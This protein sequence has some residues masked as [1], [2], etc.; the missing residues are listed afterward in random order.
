[1]ESPRNRSVA[2]ADDSYRTLVLVGLCELPS[3][4]DVKPAG[5]EY[6]SNLQLPAPP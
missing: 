4:L 5:R 3:T 6:A 1:M 2:R